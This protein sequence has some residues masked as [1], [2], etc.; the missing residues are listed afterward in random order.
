VRAL[1]ER[2]I[3]MSL[4]NDEQVKEIV[5][6]AIEQIKESVIQEA[7][8]EVTWQV[9]STVATEVN[10]IVGEFVRTEIAPSII[11]EL[12]EK[13]SI[14]INAAIA[15]SQEMAKIIA[16]SM[17]KKL[18]ENLGTSYKASKILKEMFD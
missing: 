13:K 6:G 15:S 9:K 10:K 8:R 12:K 2:E 4:L 1:K 3:T 16:E 5:A 11:I 18:A 17:T 7:T 14:I